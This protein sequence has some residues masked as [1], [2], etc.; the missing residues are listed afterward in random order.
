MWSSLVSTLTLLRH[1]RV[2]L[3]LGKRRSLLFIFQRVA[4]LSGAFRNL[5]QSSLD[6]KMTMNKSEKSACT[7]TT[8]C[9]GRSINL[10]RTGTINKRS[11]SW[12]STTSTCST[13]YISRLQLSQT[14]PLSLKK[15][16]SKYYSAM[17]LLASATWKLPTS[18][19][20][21][22]HLSMNRACQRNT[23][24][25]T[26]SCSLKYWPALVSR[27]FIKAKS[28]SA[29]PSLRRSSTC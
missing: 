10:W 3:T 14:G 28:M 26:D 13:L 12:S 24:A 23:K 19:S 2:S 17:A 16:W 20:L 21:S 4:R 6:G 1:I 29:K 25:W 8:L 18:R 5:S 27:C 7:I 15:V 11:N 22:T 9:T